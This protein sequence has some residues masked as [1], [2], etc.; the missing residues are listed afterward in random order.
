MAYSD[1][2]DGKIRITRGL[3]THWFKGVESKD[4]RSADV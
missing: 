4:G 2:S 3:R 1:V